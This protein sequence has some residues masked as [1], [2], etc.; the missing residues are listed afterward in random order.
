MLSSVKETEGY[1]SQFLEE[2]AVIVG[3]LGLVDRHQN[4]SRYFEDWSGDNAGDGVAV[5][6]PATVDEVCKVVRLCANNDVPV[7]PQGGNTGLVGG[8]VKSGGGCVV[9][10]LERLNGLRR[11]DPINLTA[12]VDAGC[13]LQ[14]V[15]TAVGDHDCAF[16]ISLGA[17]GSAQIGGIVSTNAGGTEVVKYGMTRNNILGL[18]VVLPDG[19]LWSNLTGLRKDNRGPDLSQLFIGGEGA[20]G[21]VTGACLKLSPAPGTVETAY[22]G[23]SGFDDAMT[24]LQQLRSQCHEFLSGYEIMSG[25]C[26][27]FAR[28]ADPDL[29]VPLDAPCAVYVLIELSCAGDLALR[30]ILEAVLADAHE[31][32]TI[33]DAAIAQNKSQASDFWRIREGLVEGHVINGYH[34]RSDVSVTLD[35]IPP[36]IDAL[37]EML[38]TEFPEWTPQA[39]GHAGDGNVHFNAI[40]PAAIGANEARSVGKRIEGRIF[41]IVGS[42]DGS[43]SAEHGIGRTKQAVFQNEGDPVSL[44]LLASF[45]HA[46]DPANLMN[47]GCLVAEGVARLAQVEELR[48]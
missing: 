12:T 36:L 21:I 32:G 25:E 24:L 41:G 3:K 44:G 8:A 43:F 42:F 45:K 38:R 2:L 47:P 11:I 28:L 10:S 48:L 1:A 35:N 26:L 30:D 40:P 17:Q 39:Y 13:I 6:R 27:A 33:I 7:I 5:V 18:E 14:D 19:T 37:E 22:I 4:L 20:F 15:K 29:R 16:P 9:I 46:I 34:V 31:A 23:C